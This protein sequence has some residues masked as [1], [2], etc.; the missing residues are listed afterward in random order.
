MWTLSA[1]GTYPRTH[2]LPPPF[3]AVPPTT[4]SR[5]FPLHHT[6]AVQ[7]HISS[8]AALLFELR[9]YVDVHEWVFY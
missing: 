7:S 3:D 1:D 5:A 9:F 8:G 4:L 2:T 6:D